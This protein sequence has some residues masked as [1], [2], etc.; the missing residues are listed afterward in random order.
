MGLF[1]VETNVMYVEIT[2]IGAYGET[3]T[4]EGWIDKHAYS[5]GML[6]LEWYNP[7]D[8]GFRDRDEFGT[9]RVVKLDRQTNW[10]RIDKGEEP[11]NI[12]DER[13]GDGS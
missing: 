12:E 8:P 7:D 2:Y 9:E 1:S 5:G 3:V 13:R 6:A 10:I 11:P 4:E